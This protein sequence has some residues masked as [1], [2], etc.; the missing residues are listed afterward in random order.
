MPYLDACRASLQ[1]LRMHDYLVTLL[2][3][4]HYRF[5]L[6]P[7]LLPTVMSPYAVT[8]ATL[9]TGHT[10][11]SRGLAYIVAQVAGAALASG[12]HVGS[13]KPVAH[14]LQSP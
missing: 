6:L 8:V 13:I 10:S 2:D 1:G 11:I 9:V 5:C 3:F 7:D 14:E 12:V 4:R